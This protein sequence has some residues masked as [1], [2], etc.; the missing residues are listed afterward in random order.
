MK[1]YEQ[2]RIEFAIKKLIQFNKLSWINKLKK[3]KEYTQG[4]CVI[5]GLLIHEDRKKY[6]MI[7]LLDNWQHN[8]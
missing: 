4:L 1:K 8:K 2:E 3:S 6:S 7:T 5:L